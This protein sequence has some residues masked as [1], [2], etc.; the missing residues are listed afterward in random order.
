MPA[1]KFLSTAL[2]ASAV[3]LTLAAG[4]ASAQIRI[5]EW[6]YTGFGNAGE[7]I[8]LTNIGAAAVNMTGWS[9]DDD[10]RTA[11]T[12]SLSS[13]GLVDPGQSVIISEASAAAFRTA[14]S[15]AS[16]VMIVG[17][18]TTNLGRA[19]EINI[20]DQFSNLVDR[21]TYNDQGV[22]TVDGPRTQN[23]SGIP[24]SLAAIGANNASLW[25]LSAVGDGRGSFASTEGNVGSPG[26][27]PFAPATTV[28]PV[29][30]AALLML[31]GL[32][33]LGAAARRN[34]S[35]QE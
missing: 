10:S 12:Q 24:G 14:W 19:D 35:R 4:S 16:S 20:F 17:G 1:R 5:T 18:N 3:A 22:G 15:L 2:G 8:E 34:A 30:G 23:F 25:L 9:F 29:P 6:A 31:G 33:L 21:L 7:F 28:I 32:G 11:G 13:F 26:S 27:S